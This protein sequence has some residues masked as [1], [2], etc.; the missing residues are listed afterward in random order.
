MIKRISYPN[1]YVP[2]CVSVFSFALEK[3]ERKNIEGE[4]VSLGKEGMGHKPYGKMIREGWI[5]NL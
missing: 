2:I 4:G 1:H 5:Y 3:K